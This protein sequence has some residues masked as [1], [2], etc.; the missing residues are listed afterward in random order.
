MSGE[1]S[2]A[3]TFAIGKAPVFLFL[4]QMCPGSQDPVQ[5]AISKYLYSTLGLSYEPSYILM[6][7]YYTFIYTILLMLTKIGSELNSSV[8]NSHYSMLTSLCKCDCA[9]RME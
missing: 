2:P 7:K 1:E 8:I 9:Y 5:K 4:L 3:Q 6:L